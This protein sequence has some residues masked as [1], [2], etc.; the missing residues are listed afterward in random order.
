MTTS[1]RAAANIAIDTS[2]KLAAWRSGRTKT[3]WF[4]KQNKSNPFLK[5]FAVP[6]KVKI[7]RY[8]SQGWS[9]FLTAF[10][11]AAILGAVVYVVRSAWLPSGGEK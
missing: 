5:D 8:I 11:G 1:D 9:Q 2:V 3:A 6:K 10:G 7:R 4:R